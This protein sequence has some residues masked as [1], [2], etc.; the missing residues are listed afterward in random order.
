ML[1]GRNP[2]REPQSDAYDY[3]V[4]GGGAAGCVI[5][6]GLARDGRYS[7]LLIEAGRRDVNPW[8]HI[9]GTFF[10]A[11]VKDGSTVV[12]EPEPGLLGQAMPVPQG[13]VLGGG[14]SVNAMCYVRGQPQDFDGWA[15]AGAQGWGFN[16]VLPMFKA[17]EANTRLA[18]PYHGRTGPLVVADQEYGHVL[19]H[20]FIEAA[21]DAGLPR[22]TDFNGASQHGAGFHQVT[23]Y[24][25]RRQSAATAFLRPAAH[26]DTL[27]VA[28]GTRV[29]RIAFSGRKASAVEVRDAEGRRRTFRARK[30][31]ILTAG[32]FQ[33][34]K[35]LMLSGIGPAAHLRQHGIDV[36]ADLPG[37]GANYQDHFQT[38]VA[39][40]L[41]RPIGLHGQDKGLKAL[42]HGLAYLLFRRGLLT[43]NIIEAGAFTDTDGSGRPDIQFSVAAMVQA[44]PGKG[45]RPIH[46]MTINPWVLRPHSRGR[47]SL[48]SSNP[49]E[50][51]RLEAA[52]L[53][54]DRDVETLRRG[55][56]LA[57]KIFSQPA[58]A[59]L[60]EIELVP[61]PGVSDAQGSNEINEIIRRNGRTVFHPSCTCRM[62]DAAD[63]GAVVDPRLRVRG[64]DG[65]RVADASVMPAVTSGNTNAPTMMIG[66]RCVD[67]VLAEA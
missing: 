30:E 37:V 59:D 46:G 47:V 40:K 32:A 54:D 4:A 21:V 38:M 23:A 41:K 11:L 43:S 62:G 14:S 26:L 64:I 42:R 58:L 25:G 16:E 7:V 65:L 22:S 61:G 55:V 67:F 27:A 36:L 66:G 57:R 29:E 24:R 53:A 1:A 39:I 44:E 12:S 52:A 31:I 3:I 33:S 34:P 9:T 35:I 28:F 13:A 2:Y 60:G 49:G 19:N 45:F 17:Q 10:K 6:G 5:A 51:I 56:V 8:I 63:A 18:E 50:R 48:R 15:A 20:A